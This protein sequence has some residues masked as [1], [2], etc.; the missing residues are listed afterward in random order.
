MKL[1]DRVNKA[2]C[3][4]DSMLGDALEWYVGKAKEC[5]CCS[6]LRGLALGVAVGAVG[7]G[8]LWGVVEVVL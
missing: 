7:M 6:A 1:I 4:P 5:W 8:A 3:A 2:V